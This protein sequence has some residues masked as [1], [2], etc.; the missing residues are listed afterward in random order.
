MRVIVVGDSP[1]VSTGFSRCTESACNALLAAKHEPI[2]LGINHHADP[3][4]FPYAIYPCIQPLDQGRDAFGTSRLPVMIDRLRP[5]VVLILQDP[6]NCKPYF[7]VLDRYFADEPSVVPPIVGWLAVDAKNM[8]A[9]PLN[10]LAHVIVW[11]QFG[12]NEL[13]AGGYEGPISIVPLGVDHDVFYPRDKAAARKA[14]GIEGDEFIIGVV[15][16]NQ[17]RKRIDLCLEAFHQLINTYD[18][19]NARLLLHVA[20][21]GDV[22]CNIRALIHYYGLKG[23]VLLSEPSI[24]KGADTA[25]LPNLYSS[26][27]CLLSMSQAEGWNLPALEA[28]ACGVPCVLPSFAAHGEYGW[29]GAAALQVP[30]TSTALTAPLNT[31][32]Y[33]IGGVIDRDQTV[34]ALR[35]LYLSPA[36]R[37]RYRQRGLQH[38]QQF[39][40]QATG[41]AVVRELERV[42]EARRQQSETGDCISSSVDIQ[43]AT[44]AS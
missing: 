24:G 41:Q 19:P 11:T 21:T 1:V 44:V 8:L 23:K 37:D 40:W 38:A 16:R 35:T 28:M 14:I 43:S 22:G 26:M 2:V 7:D 25:E 34:Q 10:R 20:P 36:A 3:H 32:A 5:D 18:M 12:V 15:G 9:K 13:R 29:T 17:P 39:S 33:T 30:C 42:V 6:W 31:L 27:D 4:D